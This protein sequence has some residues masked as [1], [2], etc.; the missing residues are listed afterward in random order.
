MTTL[1]DKLNAANPQ[2]LADLLRT[3]KLGEMIRELPCYK[4]SQAPAADGYSLATLHVVKLPDDAKASNVFR[5]TGKA[6]GVTGEYAPQSYGTT[7]AT[8]Q[9]AVTPS[10]DLAFLAADA[11]TSVDF[12]YLPEQGEVYEATFDVA[13]NAITIP[14]ALAARVKFMMEAEATTAGSTGKKIILAPGAGAPAA[15]Q[16]RL[17]VAKTTVT[18]AAAD[19]VT[20][21]RVKF[22]LAPSQD[23][24][25]ALEAT[26]PY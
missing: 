2:E 20:K 23:L 21:A 4:H 19:A 10:G 9:C 12:T 26:A 15:G 24:S 1:K 3:C 8:G 7:P 13:T 22:L 16:A 25:A 6:G 11:V 17:N 18:F 5:A 14:A